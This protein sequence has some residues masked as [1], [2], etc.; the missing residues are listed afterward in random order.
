MLEKASRFLKVP[1]KELRYFEET[2][3]FNNNFLQGYICNRSDYRYGSLV[4]TKI[5]DEVCE[6]VVYCTPK[7]HYP[8]DK[9]GKFN[10]PP[11]SQLEVWDK[12]DGTN[13][14]A[15]HY[16]YQGKDYV[17]FKTRLTPVI[18]NSTNFGLFYSLWEEYYNS[19]FWIKEVI[20]NNPDYNLSFE[21][22]GSRNPITV[23]YDKDLEVNLLFGVRRSDHIIKPPSQLNTS[24]KTKLP[25]KF[26]ISSIS[27]LDKM[28]QMLREQCSDKNRDFL[29]TEGVVLYAFCN[30][31]SWRQFKCKAKQI[32]EIHWAD[33]SIPKHSI[34]TTAINCFE[35]VDEPT[36]DD[37]IELLKEEYTVQQI[38]RCRIRLSKIFKSVLEHMDFVKQVNEI[39][40]LAKKEGFNIK[41][42]KN[43]TMRFISKYFDRRDMRKVGT[44]VLK[45]ANLLR[46]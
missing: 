36:L 2:D 6:Q 44:V 1:E 37:L 33:S 26:E 29:S 16:T 25:Q 15:Y 30:E 11:I 43:S 28:Y 35:N 27:D 17:S 9:Q 13:I 18:K 14:L 4:L 20:Q 23:V 22:F 39:W 42:D 7:L 10:W 46:R 32:E 41:E 21:L 19:N 5:N 24:L 40:Q 8:F 34:W 3:Y 38:E 31:P 45:Q 12:L